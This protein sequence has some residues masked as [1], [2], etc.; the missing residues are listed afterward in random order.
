MIVFIT[1]AHPCLSTQSPYDKFV[2]GGLLSYHYYRPCESLPQDF[3]GIEVIVVFRL[4]AEGDEIIPNNFVV[5]AW[6]IREV[7]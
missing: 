2:Y 1:S 7:A 6:G 5:S 3:I 4:S